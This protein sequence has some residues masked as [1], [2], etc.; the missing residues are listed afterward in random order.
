LVATAQT[1][2]KVMQELEKIGISNVTI[3]RVDHSQ[4]EKF[5][6]DV[7]LMAAKNAREKAFDMAKAVGQGVGAAIHIQEVEFNNPPYMTGRMN[8]MAFKVSADFNKEESNAPDIEFEKIKL[9]AV[10]N[11]KFE[12]TG[13][14]L[15]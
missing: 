1:A 8:E 13:P 6:R 2:G 11:A 3:E 9:E 14:S 15:F 10:V 4:I 7:K 5:R 12:L